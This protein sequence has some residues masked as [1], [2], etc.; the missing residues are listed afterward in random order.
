MKNGKIKQPYELLVRWKDGH[1]AGAH[2]KEIEQIYIDDELITERE[3]DPIPIKDV[4][5]DLAGLLGETL[6]DALAINQEL[7]AYADK[8]EKECTAVKDDCAKLQEALDKAE[9]DKYA[10]IA[11]RD[12]A[13]KAAEETSNLAESDE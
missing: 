10:A 8:L 5:E 4:A 3:C 7:A 1:L 12:A 9:K 6:T 2:F 11:E 13:I